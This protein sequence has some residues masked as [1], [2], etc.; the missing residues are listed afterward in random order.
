MRIAIC[1]FGQIRKGGAKAVPNIIRY[2][3]DLRSHCDIFVHTWDETSIGN[4]VYYQTDTGPPQGDHT[5]FDTSLCDKDNMK[6]F[7]SM[8]TPRI[9]QVEEY[10]IQNTKSLWGGRRFDPVTGKWNVSMWRS[11]QES[12]KSKIEYAQKNKIKYD[13]TVLMRADIVFGAEKTLQDDINSIYQDN[14]LLFGDPWNVFPRCGNTRLEDIFFVGKTEAIDK[15][16]VFSDFYSQTVGNLDDPNDPEYR[17]WQ[18]YSAA[19]V[20]HHLHLEM[21]PLNNSTMRIFT[22]LDVNAGTDPLDPKFGNP[23]GDFAVKRR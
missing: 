11:L 14:V 18:L 7:Y 3:G 17:D 6:E 19:W 10:S 22:H 23:P 4:G 9:M 8:I 13:F 16:S 1:F 2:I 5:W 12:N 15:F 20:T 21:K